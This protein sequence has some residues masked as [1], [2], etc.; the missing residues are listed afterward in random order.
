MAWY[1]NVD[2][3]LRRWSALSERP[4]PDEGFSG[5]ADRYVTESFQ[6][7]LADAELVS[8]LDGT[9]NAGLKADV[10][11]GKW[12]AVRPTDEQQAEAKKQAEVQRLF[13]SKPF[14]SGDLTSQMK[15][16]MLNPEL[17]SQEEAAALQASGRAAHS[18]K[19]VLQREADQKR[20]RHESMLK[21][22]AMAQGETAMRLRREQL[23]KQHLGDLKAGKVRK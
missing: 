2:S 1:S 9:C 10:L 8:I 3:V 14:I 7:R 12:D 6:I 11:A 15:L 20:A 4:L 19:E 21:G 5:F 17:A 23:I 13:D 22:V 18:E 16:R